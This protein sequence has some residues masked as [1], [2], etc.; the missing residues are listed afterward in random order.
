MKECLYT[1][2]FEFQGG[3]YISQVRAATPGEAKKLWA[4]QLLIEA[5]PN[6]GTRMQHQ[7]IQ[8]IDEEN[9]VA[10]NDVLNVWC[11]AVLPAGRFGLVTFM[12]TSDD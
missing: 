4:K 9:V 7:L 10:I 2:F 6:F 5:I 1:F 11:F 8:D 12:K 3:T